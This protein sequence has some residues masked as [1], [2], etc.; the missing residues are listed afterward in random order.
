[1]YV[2]LPLAKTPFIDSPILTKGRHHTDA[3]PCH[4]C[5][6]G[7]MP[8]QPRS[9]QRSHKH[10]LRCGAI[11]MDEKDPNKAGSMTHLSHNYFNQNTNPTKLDRRQTQTHSFHR[12]LFSSFGSMTRISPYCEKVHSKAWSSDGSVLEG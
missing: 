3:A 5:H 12:S 7:K 9:T 10:K 6:Q 1:M 2:Q 8:P 4:H 11:S